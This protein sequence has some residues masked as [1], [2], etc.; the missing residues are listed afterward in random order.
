MRIQIEFCCTDGK[1]GHVPH[2]HSIEAWHIMGGSIEREGRVERGE[3]REA[4]SD[5]LTWKR[6]LFVPA[7]AAG[8]LLIFNLLNLCHF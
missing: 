4:L 7:S 6:L 1:A 8:N 5:I 3:R 2:M